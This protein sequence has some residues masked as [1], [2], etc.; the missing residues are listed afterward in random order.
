LATRPPGQCVDEQ[1]Q[2]ERVLELTPVAC[3]AVEQTSAPAEVDA[4]APLAAGGFQPICYQ[5]GARILVVE[6][7]HTST[8]CTN[9]VGLAVFKNRQ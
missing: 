1:Q 4:D 2:L 5:L 7:E 8:L 6:Y 3:P 9:V